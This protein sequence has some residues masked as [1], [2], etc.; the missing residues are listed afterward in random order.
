MSQKFG[1]P[2]YIAPEVLKKNYTSKCDIWSIGVILYI[3]L[4]GYPPFNGANDKQI[5]EA[6]MKGKYTLEEPEW[7]DISADAKDL[8]KRMLEYDPAKR[9]SAND[10]LQHK[11]IKENAKD[12]KVERTLATKTL[13]NLRNFRV[14]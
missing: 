2:Y 5:I 14:S 6:V 3:L 4:C 11:W 1:T 10:A 12:E 9:I 7:D 8:V 13:S